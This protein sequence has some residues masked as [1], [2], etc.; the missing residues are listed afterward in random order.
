MLFAIAEIIDKFIF[1]NII[2]EIE[3]SFDYLFIDTILD[4][5]A[6]KIKVTIQM[7]LKNFD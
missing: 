2:H 3:N 6:Q 1:Y 5:K 7:Q 4:L